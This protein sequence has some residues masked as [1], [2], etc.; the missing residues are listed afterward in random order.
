RVGTVSSSDVG[1]K[2]LDLARATLRT[3][4]CPR[5]EL[6]A[7]R[8]FFD[9]LFRV[10]KSLADYAELCKQ[11]QD[12]NADSA[13]GADSIVGQALRLPV[14]ATEAVT[15]ITMWL[16]RP[17]H[18]GAGASIDLN[19]FAFLDEER[20]V[21]LLS[22]LERGRLGDIARSIAAQAFRRFDNL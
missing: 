1:T 14:R 22:S 6:H 4:F 5:L 19:R 11:K 21:D 20:N 2:V 3:T 15:T 16:S 13:D 18:V 17:A 7:S 8:F 12:G 10:L 9:P